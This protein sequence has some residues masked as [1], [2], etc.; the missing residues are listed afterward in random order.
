M[1]LLAMPERFA[2]RLLMDFGFGSL[3]DKFEQHIGRGPT[4]A[5]LW[6]AALAAFVVCLSSIIK[7]GIMPVMAAVRGVSS[8]FTYATIQ[9]VTIALV[10]GIVSGFLF[11]VAVKLLATH[12][13]KRADALIARA[14]Q[15]TN[16]AERR[17]DEAWGM[18]QL[19]EETIAEVKAARKSLESPGD[20][21]PSDVS[22]R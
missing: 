3:I 11:V 16:D 7:D 9:R 1:I 5:L 8:E 12:F 21:T 14:E 18:I 15:V 17:V 10:T 4:R 22:P 20:E 19:A 6:L 13:M 2:R